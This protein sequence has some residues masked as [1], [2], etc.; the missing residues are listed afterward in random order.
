MP[1]EIPS[2]VESVPVGAI[3]RSCELRSP[4]LRTCSF[5]FSNVPNGFTVEETEGLYMYAYDKGLKGITIFRD[6][7]KRLGILNIDAQLRLHLIV[8][9]HQGVTYRHRATCAFARIFAYAAPACPARSSCGY[10]YVDKNDNGICDFR[11]LW[12][13]CRDVAPCPTP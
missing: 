13:N 7:C 4:H 5:V 11:E 12:E 1:P 9:I 3:V 6:G 10:R 2:I 8:H